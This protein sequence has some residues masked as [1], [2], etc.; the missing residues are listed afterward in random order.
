[1]DVHVIEC[2]TRVKTIKELAS[3]SRPRL[4]M[5]GN[6][7]RFAST[8]ATSV[9]SCPWLRGCEQLRTA[10]LDFPDVVEP[11][12]SN[13]SAL[14]PFFLFISRNTA[15]TILVA[16]RRALGIRTADL[17]F[18]GRRRTSDPMRTQ[19]TSKFS[20]VDSAHFR[21]N[22]ACRQVDSAHFRMNSACRQVDSA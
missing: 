21:M 14:R 6:I 11:A 3:G 22:S 4:R 20:L 15:E 1:M 5:P 18:A 19:P 13:S 12:T 8:V 2:A 7:P 9:A 16:L 17:D 10:D